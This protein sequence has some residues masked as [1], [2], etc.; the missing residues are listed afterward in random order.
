MQARNE[1]DT[2]AYSAERSVEEYKDKV[3]AE[4]VSEI[5]TAISE[6]RAAKESENL[7]ELKAKT[8]TLS[9]AVQKIGESMRAKTDEEAPP[10]PDEKK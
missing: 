2:L 10:S 7:E 3:P 6:A 8:E 1:L 5:E 4:I 9:K